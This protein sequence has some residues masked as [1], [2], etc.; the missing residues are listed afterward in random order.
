MAFISHAPVLYCFDRSDF[1]DEGGVRLAA[2]WI[3]PIHA[4][5]G[6]SIAQTL[7]D[8]TNYVR[9]KNKTSLNNAMAYITNW[10]KTEVGDL[11]T[12]YACTPELSDYEELSKS[13][14]IKQNCPPH[15]RSDLFGKWLKCH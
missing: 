8:R 15:F 1:Y 12:A 3:R 7:A 13:P 4:N 9:D 11:V 14:A 10:D 6:K 2:T 5:K